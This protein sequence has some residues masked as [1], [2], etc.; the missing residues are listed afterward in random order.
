MVGN[1]TECCRKGERGGGEE[2]RVPSLFYLFPFSSVRTF[3]IF[4]PF[5]SRSAPEGG[6]KGSGE[7]G[8]R[9]SLS[10]LD[11]PLVNRERGGATKRYR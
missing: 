6:P 11:W 10:A 7:G 8:R 2:E 4:S 5:S 9:K 1:L 3:P